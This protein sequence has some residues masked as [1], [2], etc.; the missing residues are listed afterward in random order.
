MVSVLPGIISVIHEALSR[1]RPTMVE[2][3][4]GVAQFIADDEARHS[5]V[6]RVNNPISWVRISVMP[7]LANID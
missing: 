4:N 6:T 3:V 1:R 5:R 7:H 2:N